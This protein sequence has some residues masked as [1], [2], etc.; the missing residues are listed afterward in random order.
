M[1]KIFGFSISLVTD[2]IL[3]SQVKAVYA[4]GLCSDEFSN[5]CKLTLDNNGANTLVGKIV[6]ILLI[7]AIVLTL[8][9]LVYGGI[10]YIT[11]GGDKAK[12]DAARSHITAAI[13]G[14]II[15]L[16]AYFI[17]NIITFV[18]TGKGFGSISIPTLIP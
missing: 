2:L 18:I 11:S 16:L 7:I 13:I 3:L 6:T 4:A 14:L 10:K 17:L 12:V 15:A 8:L 1:K 9:Y 5:L